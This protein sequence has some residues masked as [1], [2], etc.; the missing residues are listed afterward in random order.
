MSRRL[1]DIVAELRNEHPEAALTEEEWSSFT[2]RFVGD[3][4]E[5]LKQKQE[6][7]V[8][9]SRRLRGQD[10]VTPT[11]SATAMDSFVKDPQD[12]E[13]ESLNP[14]RAEAWRLTELTGLDESRHKQLTQLDR[15]ISKR[16]SELEAI[17]RD[18]GKATG[19]SQRA[20]DLMSL[21][22]DAYE[23]LFEGF[24]AELDVFHQLYAPLQKILGKQ[25]GTLQRLSFTVSR[26]VD[27][28][29]WVDRGEQLLDLR[30]GHFRRHGDLLKEAR[31][32]LLGP[33]E[34]GT[35]AE[36][37]RAL[38]AF[39]RE[40]HERLLAQARSTRKD[41][42]SRQM[43]A[44]KIAD[45]LFDTQHI[46][47]QYGMQYDGVSMEQLSPGTRGILLLMLYLSLDQSDDRPL[48]IDQPEENLDPSSVFD[49]LVGCFVRARKK[50][51]IVIVTHNANLVINTDAVQ[52]IVADPI[53]RRTGQLPVF[54]YLSGGIENAAIREKVCE[55]LEGG[56]SAFE[57]RAKRLRIQLA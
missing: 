18:I 2:L 36:V 57:E 48:I 6:T 50:R 33:W 1:P 5:F 43:A 35:P 54:F 49:E 24:D 46:R 37:A 11:Q 41:P 8:A 52:I 22:R 47:L 45:W 42:K 21:R 30:T 44:Q 39:A 4:L 3:P 40:N 51:Q 16:E 28:E 26:F 19:A 9:E 32:T 12:I 25:D 23:K 53:E 20:E 10:F 38:D 29:D 15:L 56:R 55:I 34:D 17:N 27:L 31:A 14:L 13:E 7:L